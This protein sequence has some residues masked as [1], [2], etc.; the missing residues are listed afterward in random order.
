MTACR[1]WPAI[2]VVLER[3]VSGHHRGG[4]NKRTHTASVVQPGSNTVLATIQLTHAANGAAITAVPEMRKRLR[5]TS[6]R[7]RHSPAFP[8]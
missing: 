3:G 2:D 1:P 5:Q 6:I 7:S 4:S 8:R